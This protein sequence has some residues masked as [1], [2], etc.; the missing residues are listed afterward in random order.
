MTYA[1]LT[2]EEQDLYEDLDDVSKL[3]PIVRD[4]AGTL[5]FQSNPVMR[6][7]MDSLCG[8]ANH[9]AN[10]NTLWI[11]AQRNHWPLEPIR[12]LYRGPATA[13]AG[14]W[15]SSEGT[16]D[17]IPPD[18]RKRCPHPIGDWPTRSG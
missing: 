9:P 17:A 5:R 14:S 3:A 18:R 6:F 7:V 10:L 13:C 2:P 15:M 4:R 12:V 1:D 8:Y 11:T 16:A